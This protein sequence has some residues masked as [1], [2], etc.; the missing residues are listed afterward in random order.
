MNKSNKKSLTAAMIGDLAISSRNFFLAATGVILN[1][2]PII[3]VLIGIPIGMLIT[4][5][6]CK[7]PSLRGGWLLWRPAICYGVLLG[8][9]NVAGLYV[10]LWLQPQ[11]VGAL[12]FLVAAGINMLPT[13]IRDA[14]AGRFSTALWPALAVPGIWA[15]V[16]DPAG[17]G[18]GLQTADSPEVVLLGQGI[19]GWAVGV[20]AVVTSS[21]AY[22][23]NSK[24]MASLA[25]ADTEG[26]LGARVSVLSGIPAMVFL[27]AGASFVGGGWAGVNSANWPYLLLAVAAGMIGGVGRLL[28]VKAYDWGLQP[29]TDAMLSPLRTLERILLGMLIELMVPS[30]LQG[31]GIVLI[32][33]SSIGVRDFSSRRKSSAD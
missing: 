20:A 9:N 19:P 8:V 11:V 1:V 14:R 16:G 12:S 32:L 7:R 15:L 17:H 3:T 21:S 22:A 33:I 23:F 13:I 30:P 18:G 27:V 25:D 2:G 31:L 29:D 24:T 26:E 4:W 28:Q 5:H 6:C 10:F